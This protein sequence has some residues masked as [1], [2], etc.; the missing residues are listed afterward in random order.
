MKRTGCPQE[1]RTSCYLASVL[2]SPSTRTHAFLSNTRHQH[3][4]S[5]TDAY[6]P[7]RTCEDERKKEKEKKKK[8][9]EQKIVVVFE[10]TFLKN[11]KNFIIVFEKFHINCHRKWILDIWLRTILMIVHF[12]RCGEILIIP[13]FQISIVHRLSFDSLGKGDISSIR[14]REVAKR[15]WILGF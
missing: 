7:L 1:N 9:K 11:L 4:P 3:T 5:D 12:N 6:T 2:V 14:S 15:W 10:T 13:D 8:K